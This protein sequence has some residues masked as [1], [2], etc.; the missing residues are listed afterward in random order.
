MKNTGGVKVYCIWKYIENTICIKCVCF[1]LPS[2]VCCNIV[3]VLF[4]FLS[5]IHTV[6]AG[7]EYTLLFVSVINELI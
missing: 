5:Q 1:Y 3:E 6:D 2:L 7:S 4:S